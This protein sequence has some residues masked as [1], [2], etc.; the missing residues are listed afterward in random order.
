MLGD[1]GTNV[2]VGHCQVLPTLLRIRS[3]IAAF[4]TCEDT[5]SLCLTGEKRRGIGAPTPLDTT[6]LHWRNIDPTGRRPDDPD[7][8]LLTM[9]AGRLGRQTAHEKRKQV[10]GWQWHLLGLGADAGLCV[11]VSQESERGPE[12]SGLTKT[13]PA[14]G[15]MSKRQA[16]PQRPS[17]GPEWSWLH[18]ASPRRPLEASQVWR[19]SS[20][21][22]RSSL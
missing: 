8:Y 1:D 20:L 11:P 21:R 18:R 12:A 3:H 22:E 5:D 4:H 13:S 6:P 9:S 7:D 16:S 2:A 15:E 10:R 14:F 19:Q 17:N